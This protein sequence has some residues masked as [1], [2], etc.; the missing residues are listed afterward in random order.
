MANAFFATDGNIGVDLISWTTATNFPLGTTVAGN[1][2][3]SW[4]Y[5]IAGSAISSCDCVHVAPGGTA[6]PISSANVFL[7]GQAAV[8]MSSA[9]SGLC[10]WV[11]LD[12]SGLRVNVLTGCAA[13]VPLYTTDNA[14][15]LDDATAS[16]S[17]LQIQ[18]YILGASNS[19]G[20]TANQ[21]L[22]IQQGGIMRRP[23]G[24]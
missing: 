15:V 7:A 14:G 21:V 11:A 10:G 6:N 17:H 8:A 5:V 24:A 16:L 2:G 19:A 1:N 22:A 12:G 20:A 9:A 3:G 4:K 18:G 23:Y 13:S